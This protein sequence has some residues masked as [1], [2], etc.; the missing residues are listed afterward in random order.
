MFNTRRYEKW[1][2]MTIFD[3]YTTGIW[4]DGIHITTVFCCAILLGL[5]HL[6]PI[7]HLFI[8]YSQTIWPA[9]PL[10]LFQRSVHI[11]HPNLFSGPSMYMLVHWQSVRKNGSQRFL[12][13]SNCSD[14]KWGVAAVRTKYIIGMDHFSSQAKTL[15]HL[16]IQWNLQS[17]GWMLILSAQLWTQLALL[18]SSTF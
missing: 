9:N 4:P 3:W 13:T 12:P 16:N 1:L 17:F 2:E 7:G 10:M 15:Q 6:I 8:K 5:I 18:K 11:I 14:Y